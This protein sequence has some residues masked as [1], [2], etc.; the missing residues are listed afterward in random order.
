[1]EAAQPDF[2]AVNRSKRISTRL[3]ILIVTVSSLLTLFLTA[4]QLVLDYRQERA[5][6]EK[7]LNEVKV[8]LIPVAAS[9]WTFDRRQIAFA[10]D[11]LIGLPNIERVVVETTN[12]KFRWSVGQQK[13]SEVVTRTYPLHYE[14]H[15][16]SQLIG[17]VEIV[18][19]LDAVFDRVI[20]RAVTLL[21]SNGLK[22]ILVVLFMFFIFRRLVTRRI[23][24]LASV[25]DKFE[26][27]QDKV[28]TTKESIASYAKADEIDIL[29]WAFYRMSELSL[30]HI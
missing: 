10:L 8:L 20:S 26:L 13:S 19:S 25:V 15:G 7:L 27:I 16:E 1:M 30:I 3:I 14:A 9:V 29:Q 24:H 21:L 11:S 6:M 17:S 22:T 23:E 12:G 18:A 28:P 2:G 4:F 5:D